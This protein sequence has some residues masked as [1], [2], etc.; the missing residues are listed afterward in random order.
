MAQPVKQF[1]DGEA[2]PWQCAR[3]GGH[4]EVEGVEG[5]EDVAG[6]AEDVGLWQQPGNSAMGTFGIGDGEGRP[7][8]GSR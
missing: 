4:V 3:D 1:C 7:G 2:C 6:A 5:V 8:I